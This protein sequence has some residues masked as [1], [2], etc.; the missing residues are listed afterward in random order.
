MVDLPALADAISRTLSSDPTQRT[1]A[2]S[3][4]KSKSSTPRFSVSLL[5][6]I[7]L[8]S[9]PSHVR[10]AAAV[11]MKNHTIETYSVAG[12]EDTPSDDR[13]AVKQAIVNIILAVPLVV[14]RQLTEVLV[15]IAVHEYPN[16][17]PQLVPELGTRLQ[18][19]YD[20]A[21]NVQPGNPLVNSVDWLA[22]EGLLETLF[23]IFDRY[24]E[25][26]RSNELYTEI[27]FSL[28]HTQQRVLHLFK[29][30]N[31]VL[32]EDI[33]SK[34][35]SVIEAVFR[36][37]ELLCKTFYCLAW[38]QLPEYFEDH[39]QVFMTEL[40]RFLVFESSTIDAMSDDEPSLVDRLHVVVLEITNHFAVHYDEE[41]RPY[42]QQFLTDTWAL[43]VKRGNSPKYDAVVTA[44][45]KFLTSV[46]R[47]PDYMLFQDV[48]VLKQ[49]CMSIVVPNIEL[50][51]EDEELFE[52][53]P[54][55]Y[56]R[57]D[58]EGSDTDTRR[59]GAVELIKGLCM[60]WEKPVTDIFASYIQEMLAPQ[61]D[62]RKKDTVI[63]VITALGW[64]KGT[65]AGG[66]TEI[67]TL[68][69]V[70]EFFTTF[71]M[72]QLNKCAA[73]PT[74]LETPIF[75]A[76]L[77]KFV[78]SFRNQ[79]PKEDSASVIFL[80][81]KL[82]AAKESVVR[83]YAAACI[84]RILTVKDKISHANGNG[85]TGNAQV[86]AAV[87]RMNKA[88]LEP[89]L[90]DLLP[91]VINALR[92]GG[93][94]NEYVM[95]LILRFCAVSQDA[96]GT[97]VSKLLPTLVEILAS[98]AANPSNPVFNHYLFETLSALIRFNGRSSTVTIFEN[99]LMAPLCKV[100][101]DDVTEFIPYVFQVFSQLMSLHGGKLPPTY[102]NLIQPTL[103]PTMWENRGY[104][105]GMVQF[106]DVYTRKNAAEVIAANQLEAILG[107]FQKLLASKATDHHALRLLDC[108]FETYDLNTLSRYIGEIFKVLMV[109]LTK[110]KT[111]KLCSNML[112]T[113]SIFVVR[114]GVKSLKT[115]LD[116]LQKD[117]LAALIRDVWLTEVVTIRK[118]DHRRLCAIAL[119]EVGCG[120]DD[121]CAEAPFHELWPQILN[122][123][124]AVT[125]GIVMD[126]DKK[127]ELND[128]TEEEASHLG[129]GES[130]SAAHSQLKWG[131]TVGEGVSGL[132][133]QRDPRVVLATKL[134][135]LMGRHPGKFEALLQNQV[136]S[137]AR[138]AVMSYTAIKSG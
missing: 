126:K 43:L 41:F 68:I 137:R 72:P 20:P 24:P 78:I 47:S 22:M 27:N 71:V 87:P 70:V 124:V 102:N 48:S 97:Y 104:V 26:T 33:Q 35:Q 80:C 83:T 77:I 61:A 25:E 89:V 103:T 66:A 45:I 62:W 116:Q 75:T 69:N 136:D 130:Y 12:W 118:P 109:R 110:A 106:L 95:R 76:D 91:A 36:N 131:A 123:N 84:E 128:S 56:V 92:E 7:A 94:A 34:P 30:M 6:L 117:M 42:L 28:E 100:L 134:Q 63:Y 135:E 121:L 5:Q 98:V 108:V 101:I 111:A 65:L 138:E 107:I 51:E 112:V 14:R 74:K 55:E 18:K 129:A 115:T 31:R 23:Y 85:T 15:I 32:A 93:R 21:A 132:V 58:M 29:L 39:L 125:E 50:R 73:N 127:E 13:D 120:P 2:E 119:A 81:V 99:A 122:T 49:I 96:M 114:F 46:S 37:V 79:I 16:K 133:R 44:G 88:D 8:D 9:A 38:Q 40:R 60:H 90:R 59:R 10:Q 67:S 86:S 11:Y 64:K 3:F 105:P 19:V 82:L 17:W 54:V 4:L 1:A 113:L 53:N 57:R 52:D